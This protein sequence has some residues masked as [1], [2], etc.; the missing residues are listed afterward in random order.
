MELRRDFLDKVFFFFLIFLLLF[1][2]LSGHPVVYLHP[3]SAEVSLTLHYLRE[4][5]IVL[6]SSLSPPHS[7]L[8]PQKHKPL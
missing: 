8:G 5:N 6:R 3:I 4:L 2:S 7:P 1:F